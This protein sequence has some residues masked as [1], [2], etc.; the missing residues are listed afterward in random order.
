MQVRASRQARRRVSWPAA[1][2]VAASMARRG[3]H[4]LQRMG[5]LYLSQPPGHFQRGRWGSPIG[6]VKEG[7]ARRARRDTSQSDSPTG[8]AQTKSARSVDTT[9]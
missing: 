4:Y 7:M 1:G 9:S 6:E 3:H 8:P 2:I 5:T